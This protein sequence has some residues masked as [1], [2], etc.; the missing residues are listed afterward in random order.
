VQLASA[1]LDGI[2]VDI[3]ARIRREKGSATP[4]EILFWLL[5]VAR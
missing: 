3:E 5:F 1:A 4:S 2:I